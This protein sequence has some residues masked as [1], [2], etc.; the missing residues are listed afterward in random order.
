MIEGPMAEGREEGEANQQPD[1]PQKQNRSPI[2]AMSD[3]RG[4]TA[5]LILG[6]LFPG[7][8]FRVCVFTVGGGG[9]GYW[10]MYIATT[11]GLR[12][13][14]CCVVSPLSGLLSAVVIFMT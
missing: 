2:D 14:S 1:D 4:T 7:I 3:T 6:Q 11:L 9:G 5:A 8:H 12:I 10:N 13:F